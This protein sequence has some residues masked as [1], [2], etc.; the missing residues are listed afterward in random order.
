MFSFDK[1]GLNG[2]FLEGDCTACGDKYGNGKGIFE[3]TEC[4]E[5][6]K[7]L[8]NI[9]AMLQKYGLKYGSYVADVGAGTGMVM[10]H[11]HSI[12]ND[13]VIDE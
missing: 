12:V 4:R 10:R 9:I 1:P 7:V 8:P 6:A 11:A 3:D 5:I 2:N 13:T